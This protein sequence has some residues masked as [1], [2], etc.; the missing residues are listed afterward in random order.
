MKR[1]PALII[2]FFFLLQS[3]ASAGIIPPSW[4][5]GVSGVSSFNGRTGAVSPSPG[6]YSFS[7]IAGQLAPG[8][9]PGIINATFQDPVTGTMQSSSPA[10][11]A[12]GNYELYFTNG[13]VLYGITNTSG[14]VTFRKYTEMSGAFTNND[15]VA[16][17][18]SGHL[19]DAGAACGG[20]SSGAALQLGNGT[21]GFA[22]YGGGTCPS[23]EF[24]NGVSA[25]GALSCVGVTGT[26]GGTVTSVGLSMPP[27]FSVSGSRVTGAG[28][29]SV[30]LANAA[31]N[32]VFAAPSGASGTPAFRSLA[33]SDLPS[34]GTCSGGA[35]VN[36]VSGGGA[37]DCSTPTGITYVYTAD[38]SN[39]TANANS[40][41]AAT[42]TTGFY[43]MTAEE[44]VTT[45]ASTSSTMPSVT[46]YWE[47]PID[48]TIQSRTVIGTSTS[49]STGNIF[50][51][52]SCFY[53]SNAHSIS[54]ETYNYASSGTPAMVYGISVRLYRQGN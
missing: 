7:Q 37:L 43:C 32:T 38:L 54:W 16:F 23:T 44:K 49:N 22:A 25:D 31:A 8:Q 26:S 15:C 11:P 13:G 34:L 40:T 20:A 5:G 14:T 53:V 39:Q 28:T 35:F 29:F 50:D 30:G 33:A 3:V 18:A 48:G 41:M 51:G 6:D 17:N 1:K 9:M 42:P 47:T 36:D 12:S 27:E 10:S 21:G 46:V 19:I 4:G 2:L 45:A 52:T 24:V